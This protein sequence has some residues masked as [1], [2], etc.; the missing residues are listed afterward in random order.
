M[1]RLIPAALLAAVLI[2]PSP[3]TAGQLAIGGV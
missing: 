3:S 2:S 1:T